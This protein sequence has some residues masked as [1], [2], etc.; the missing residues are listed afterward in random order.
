[1][2]LILIDKDNNK[3]N[4]D[5]YIFRKLSKTYV[6]HIESETYKLFMSHQKLEYKLDYS[7]ESIEWLIKNT[8]FNFTNKIIEQENFNKLYSEKF[9][10]FVELLD[11]SFY[12]QMEII[13]S[14]CLLRI[15]KFGTYIYNNEYHIISNELI[16]I[17]YKNS[18]GLYSI[19]CDPHLNVK[20]SS[21]RDFLKNHGSDKC[22]KYLT[23]VIIL[24]KLRNLTK[25]QREKYIIFIYQLLNMTDRI[26]IFT[27]ISYKYNN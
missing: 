27:L 15:I 16:K 24:F 18:S 23:P 12:L 19:D 10:L 4:I 22:V 3:H 9:S 20:S 17:L 6:N 7:K 14:C 13:K 21:W 5:E 11:M 8:K 26:K 1:M 25:K 2:T